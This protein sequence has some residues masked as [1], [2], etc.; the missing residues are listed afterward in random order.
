MT[1]WFTLVLVFS[2]LKYWTSASNIDGPDRI[3][4]TLKIL[5]NTVDDLTDSALISKQR[6]EYLEL[7]LSENRDELKQL[8]IQYDRNIHEL[9]ARVRELEVAAMNRDRQVITLKQEKEE[10]REYIHKVEQRLARLEKKHELTFENAYQ[11]RNTS[12]NLAW[13]DMRSPYDD[14]TE[15]DQK[16]LLTPP[17]TTHGAVAFYAYMSTI[18]PSPSAQHVLVFDVV[19]TNTGNAYHPTT[20]VFMVPESGVYVFTWTY[21]IGGDHDHSIQLMINT[22]DCGSL[23]LHAMS[24]TEMEGTGIVVTHV[25]AGDDVYVRTHASYQVGTSHY[26]QSNTYGRSSFAGWKLF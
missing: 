16:R 19:K 9:E 26:I 14:S 20:G 5:Q 1:E 12:T 25:N 3:R 17:S 7:K 11:L 6:N 22:E 23:Y 10:D 4:E 13:E 8:K 24:G 21:R 2:I 15:R 18:L